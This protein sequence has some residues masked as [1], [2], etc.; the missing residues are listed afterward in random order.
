MNETSLSLLDQ[1]RRAPESAAWDRFVAL[2][3]PLLKSWLLRFDVQASDADDL[4]QEM[5]L[6]VMRELPGFE[7]VQRAGAFR[8]WLRGIL[9]NRIRDFWRKRDYRPVTPATTKFYQWLE[10]LEDDRSHVSQLWDREHDQFVLH[11][12]LELVRDRFEPQTWQVF[13]RLVVDEARPDVVATEM[14]LSLGSV[15]VAKSRVLSVL[16]QEAAGLIDR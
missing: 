1:L 6:V 12:L 5:L 9:A 2:Y 16:R 10:E 3:G 11:R 13:R 8:A 7:H 4:V 14:G 15:Y